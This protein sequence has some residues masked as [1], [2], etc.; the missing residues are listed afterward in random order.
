MTQLMGDLGK[1]LRD[2]TTNG[3]LSIRNHRHERNNQEVF[4]LGEQTRQ[5]L[6]T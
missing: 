6:L 1:D 2:G 3:K 5:I 4:D